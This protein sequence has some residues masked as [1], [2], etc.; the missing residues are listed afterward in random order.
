MVAPVTAGAA[1]G[2]ASRDFD[3]SDYIAL[4]GGLTFT[5]AFTVAA[6][7]K[8]T[9]TSKV[10]TVAG[11]ISTSTDICNFRIAITNGNAVTVGQFTTSG[12]FR[13]VNG[14]ALP[15]NTW[16]H[17][18]LTWDGDDLVMYVDGSA[19]TANYTGLTPDSSGLTGYIGRFTSGTGVVNDR[20]IG[21]IADARIYSRAISAAE[22]ANLAARTDISSTG[23]EG[24][25]LLNDDDVLDYSGNG[26]DGTN[27]GSTYSTDGPLD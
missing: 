1:F 24:W 6:W 10:R 14:G 15:N 5:S 27:F 18:C 21:L 20:W 19:T 25:W 16:A 7:V 9:S 2:L 23:L 8:S 26:N 3:G 4:G 22:A 12:T 11:N 13:N 17:V